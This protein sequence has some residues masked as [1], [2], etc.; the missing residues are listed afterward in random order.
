M[1]DPGTASGAGVVWRLR[2]AALSRLDEFLP[3]YDFSE[4]HQ[5][6]VDAPPDRALA[7]AREAALGDMPLVRILFALR[8]LPAI[9]GRRG[10]LPAVKD[11]PLLEQMLAFGFVPLAEDP[12][13]LVVGYVGQPWKV[14]GGTMPRISGAD[15][16]R[17]FDHSGFAKAVMNF[18]A[19]PGARTTLATETRILLT[20]PESRRR[21]ARYWR[22][23]RPGSGTIRRVWLNAAKKRVEAGYL[24]RP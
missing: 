9:L 24:R 13:E 22:V 12:H 19:E 2:R 15:E 18:R 21:F 4:R 17:A 16:F 11:E 7:G 23:I 14:A 5:I 8:S 20:D 10:R 1:L 3:H 6:A